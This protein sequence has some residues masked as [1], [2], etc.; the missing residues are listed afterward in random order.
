MAKTLPF[1]LAID[2]DKKQLVMRVTGESG[3]DAVGRMDVDQIAEFMAILSQCQQALVLSHAGQE[4]GLP[5]DPNIAFDD[6]GG[7][8]PQYFE[9]HHRHG[10]GPHDSGGVAMIM[11]T[12]KGRLTSICVSSEAAQNLGEGLLKAAGGT[13]RPQTRQ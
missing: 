13:A 8:V 6:V 4:L 7:F 11:L 5:I 9:V 12:R 2:H 1:R 10:V 3:A